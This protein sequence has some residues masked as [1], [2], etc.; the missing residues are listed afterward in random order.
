MTLVEMLSRPEIKVMY[1]EL[2]KKY[3]PDVGGNPEVMKRINIAKDV[4]D[5]AMRHIYNE[6]IKK[7]NKKEEKD[8]FNDLT[9]TTKE[10]LKKY[11]K[12]ANWIM[13]YINSTISRDFK[14][15][16]TPRAE[17][18]HDKI[19]INCAVMAFSKK[20]K[21]PIKSFTLWN[22]DKYTSKEHLMDKILSNF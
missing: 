10:K 8:Y 4:G 19:I 9:K 3:H 12:W 18:S 5:E 13:N 1:K 15:F 16:V 2:V 14:I 6:L 21:E 20:K 7:E 17:T 22:I 11:S